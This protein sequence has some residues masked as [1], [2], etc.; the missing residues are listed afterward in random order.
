MEQRPL[1]L[2]DTVDDY[3]PRE[4]RT[5]NHVIVAIVGDAIRQTRCTT[6]D[7]DHP[8]KGVRVSRRRKTDDGVSSDTSTP[9]LLVPPRP[10]GAPA[11][12]PAVSAASPQTSSA[13]EPEPESEMDEAQPDQHGDHWPTHRRLIRA[14]LPKTEGELPPPRPIPEF[15]MHQRPS[16]RGGFGGHRGGWSGHSGGAGN[17]NANGNVNGNVRHPQGPG[18]SQGHGPSNG[19]GNGQGPGHGHGP[20][21]HRG[22]KHRRPR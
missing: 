6:C 21:R 8:F 16:H 2:G 20:R 3:C 9:G 5:T 13:S 7:A 17:G 14:A 10:A 1:R 4:R 19:Q 15:T 18:R 22:G 11:P 12:E